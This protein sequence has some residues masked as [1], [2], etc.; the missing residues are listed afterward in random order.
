MIFVQNVG[1]PIAWCDNLLYNVGAGGVKWG[2]LGNCP[3][4]PQ[5]M[6]CWWGS[7]CMFLGQFS[8]T[9]DSKGRLTIPSRFREGLPAEV[10]VTRGM[11]RCLVVYPI[12]VWKE[13]SEKVTS[14]SITDRR[15]RS[16]R[17]LLFADAINLELDRQGRVLIPDR[18]RVYAGLE[19]SS[20][21][22]IVGLDSFVELWD[23][24]RWNIQNDSQ[25]A[26]LGEDP[27]IWE[28]LQI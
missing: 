5:E 13:I 8:Y 7:H 16:L 27:A 4:F 15:A 17:R 20:D 3:L 19:L 9:L 6:T 22:V 1:L 23:P 18:L 14:L 28:S 24:E 25:M 12:D 21:V 2:K 26:T 11:D 10:V